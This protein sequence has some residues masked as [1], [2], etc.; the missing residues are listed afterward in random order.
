[1]RT[2]QEI[3]DDPTSF[4]PCGKCG[5]TGVY[6]SPNTM[7][8]YDCSVC[9]GSGTI[10][11]PRA[12][13][14]YREA[15]HRGIEVSDPTRE[16]MRRAQ[17]AIADPSVPK[18]PAY[19]DYVPPGT[20]SQQ[21]IFEGNS[22]WEA[23]TD[24]FWSS[25]SYKDTKKAKD[26]IKIHDILTSVRRWGEPTEK[27]RAAV[28]RLVESL[29]APEREV[30]PVPEGKGI[31]I[32]GEVISVKIKYSQ[33]GEQLKMLVEDDR[34]FRVWGSVP[35]K[36]SDVEKGNRVTFRASV[37]R[38]LDDAGFGFYKRPTKAEII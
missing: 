30:V 15:Q 11:T 1:M 38:S 12:R 23:D 3:L 34:G 2:I 19:T 18:P 10:F 25:L 29:T 35:K 8:A 7:R 36:I 4:Q 22:A 17:E 9:R 14:E 31:Q 6:E 26:A 21:K 16:W 13:K 33:Y 27:Q 20:R 28:N 24:L 5:G 32:T 37:E